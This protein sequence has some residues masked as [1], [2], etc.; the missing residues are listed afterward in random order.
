MNRIYQ[1]R[2]SNVEI[3]GNKETPWLPYDSDP[4]IAREKWQKS[5]AEHHQLFQDA[6]NYHICALASLGSS[7]G[8]K[9]TRLRE[10]LKS[11]WEGFDKKG[12]H[13][14]G[15]RD[16]LQ[17]ALLF[18]KPPTLEKVMN[19]FIKPLKSDSIPEATY[20]KAG[21]FLLFKLGGDTAI[22]QGGRDFLPMFCDVDS[23]ATF[24]LS[25]ERRGRA[26][27]ELRLQ[28]E[29]HK[30]L[31]QKEITRL[32]NSITLGSVVNLQP[33]SKPD[34]GLVIHERLK[35]AAKTFEKE[36]SKELFEKW[37]SKLDS[38]FSLPKSRG[39]NINAKRVD[40]CMLFLA[41]PNEITKSIFQG[42]FSAPKE[43]K[44]IH[45][46]EDKGKAKDDETRFIVD[47]DDPI[48]LSR[49]R[50]GFVYKGFTALPIWNGDGERMAW[51]EF[52][53]AA[54]KE[55]LKVYNQFQQNL[56]KREDKLTDFASKLLI[57]DGER[58]KETYSSKDDAPLRLLLEK[59]WHDTNGKPKASTEES[60]EE[61][62]LPHFTG[63]PR[64]ERLRK[65]VNSD[66]AEEYRLTD[67]RRTP[68]GLR[69]RTMKGWNEVKRKWQGIVKWGEPF[70]TEKQKKLKDV[71]DDLR[72]GEKREQIGSHKL[73]EALI[74]D[75]EA[76]NI[77]REPDSKFQKQINESGWATDPLDAFRE[78]CEIREA[79]EEVFTRPLNFTPADARYSRRLFMFTDVCSF[80]KDTGDYRHD[81]KNL[82]VIVPVAMK[83]NN[84]KY[85]LQR[86]RLSYSAPRL[87]RDHIRD[88]NGNYV[89]DWTQP[90][91]A[92]L[93]GT[94]EEVVNPQQLKDAAVQLMPDFNTKGERRFLLNFPLSLDDTLI[95][96]R[97]GKSNLWEKQFVSWKKGAQLPFLRWENDFDGKEPFR[98]WKKVTSFQVLAADLGTRHAASVAVIECSKKRKENSRFIG[99]PDK[100]DWFGL[101]R[102]GTILR[103]PGE[104]VEV[105][106]LK[107]E[108]DNGGAAK[109]FREELYGEKGR[110]AE[111]EECEE[112][113]EILAA[114]NQS[115]LL[116]YASSVE[117]LRQDLSFPEQNDK[118]L[119]AVRRAQNWIATCRSWCWK[120]T[121]PEDEKQVEATLTQ[122]QEQKQ[123][124]QWQKLANGNKQDIK[125]LTKALYEAIET[126]REG[127]QTQLLRLT[128][129]ILPLRNR[130]WE[131]IEHPDKPD[132]H[133][134][135][136][137]QEGTGPKHVKLRGQRGLG[138]IRIEQISELR[139]RW[140]S[141][142]QSLRTKPD[143]RPLTA[144]E[145]RNEII[146][147]PCPDILAKLEN[148]R[149]QRVNQTAHLILAQALGVRL[150][151]P[152]LSSDYREVTD[153]HGE[154]EVFRPPVDMIVLEDLSRYLSDQ[155][156]AKSENTRLMKWCHRQVLQKVKMLAQPFGISVLET[157]AAYS[158]RFCSLTGAAGFRAAE[159]GWNC[160]DDFPWRDQLE[161]KLKDLEVEIKE[162]AGNTSK[163]ETLRRKY[164]IVKTVKVLF[165]QLKKIN[166]TD[167]PYHTLLAPQAGG[168]MFVTAK[169]ILHPSPSKERKEKGNI[170]VLPMQ[171]DLNAAINLAFRA[172]AHPACADIHHRLR[173]EHKKNQPDTFLTREK[174]RFGKETVEIRVKEG[175]WPPK[176][177]KTN[178]FYD[179]YGIASFGRARLENEKTTDFPY[180]SGPGLWKTVNDRLKQWDR[181]MEINKE[182]L[183]AWGI[184]VK[185]L[186]EKS[187]Q[188]DDLPM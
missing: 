113:F 164:T 107:T 85:F 15:M 152:K 149:E 21:E 10:L 143:Q 165:D 28:Q 25:S 13:R 101:Y 27:D 147:D 29:L 61:V 162:S 34:T 119:V 82:A 103:L 94:T 176:E 132:C 31:S 22:Q 9:L 76:W 50:R 182:R 173:T 163:Q 74:S 6:V 45:A 112:T 155:G 89:Q 134:L 160:R 43:K 183:K 178:F 154:Y 116:K 58:A 121:Q 2:V 65:I 131:W 102:Y 130:R 153:T 71:L 109:D 125:K 33:D 181:C 184:S 100:E 63:D 97:I 150:R 26:E 55:A 180:A 115:D 12:Q 53:I 32:S 69:R 83:N 99:S 108:K 81:L 120:L 75:E 104:N 156:R 114:L 68:Y 157:P 88:E 141:L 39:G 168:P 17:R 129:R 4:K 151:R 123:M 186:T 57:M 24:K 137:T 20:E 59:V 159:I 170:N 18:D 11:V 146:P 38:K 90:M 133:L 144:A 148:I 135:Q 95:K 185:D 117:K 98:W 142:N 30:N 79:M 179:K 35:V 122:I 145:M 80:G 44:S 167:H 60:G 46:D 118:L 1:G 127:V 110:L 48:K 3:P 128:N 126:Q 92:A 37:L 106:R 40:A 72:G 7:P 87:L 23:K 86:C 169:E 47:G 187:N 51:K 105:L 91:M 93:F 8:G 54:F 36:I 77:W 78:Y 161:V 67:G 140:Q 124:P 139:R 174:R 166:K 41:F 5:L 52:D 177:S 171:A 158:S 84:G 111:R 188:D 73:F 19:W 56:E 42:T 16:S 49:G 175:N 172:V 62:A 66:L 64:I 14:D 136:Q 138:M 70:T 96:K